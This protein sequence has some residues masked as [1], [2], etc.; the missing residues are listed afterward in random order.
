MSSQFA[1]RRQD[2]A[3]ATAPFEVLFLAMPSDL[4]G[5]RVFG[6]IDR[7]CQLYLLTFQTVAPPVPSFA[8]LSTPLGT[9]LS[10]QSGVG[11]SRKVMC[12]MTTSGYPKTQRGLWAWAYHGIWEVPLPRAKWQDMVPPKGP[13]QAG[14]NFR[15]V[16]PPMARTPETP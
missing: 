13:P 7:K 9:V 8:D 1:I 14:E 12:L 5:P 11:S 10:D 16:V 6:L 2:L 4:S 3:A 15:P